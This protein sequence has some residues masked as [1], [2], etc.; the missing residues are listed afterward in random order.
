MGLV[1]A[2]DGHSGGQGC[3][4]VASSFSSSQREGLCHPDPAGLCPTANATPWQSQYSITG[5]FRWEE[6]CG[7]CLLQAY[8][9][10]H[11][12][13]QALVLSSCCPLTPT[14]AIYSTPQLTCP[15]LD[16]VQTSQWA[17]LEW[18][19]VLLRHMLAQPASGL[20]VRACTSPFS[21]NTARSW[22]QRVHEHVTW[23]F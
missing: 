3:T 20:V 14:P 7:G 15:V 17:A 13:N 23:T 2:T 12:G 19:P 8:S 10:H 22:L 6:A 21:S 9:Y 11:A 5:T 18:G 1:Q 16:A 4:A